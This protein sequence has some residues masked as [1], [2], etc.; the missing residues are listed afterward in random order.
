V[1]LEAEFEELV[2]LSAGVVHGCVV[3]G[4][5]VRDADYAGGLEGSTGEGAFVP[6]GRGVGVDCIDAWRVT[7][8][9]IC[10]IRAVGSIQRI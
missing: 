6:A 1:A 3:L 10:R 2:A 5:T 9:A 8:N 7:S 4:D